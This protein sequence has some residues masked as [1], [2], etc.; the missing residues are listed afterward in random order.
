MTTEAPKPEDK[1]KR[2]WQTPK[3]VV[4]S[5]DKTAQRTAVSVDGHHPGS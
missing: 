2:P 3:L 1:P 5:I 4:I